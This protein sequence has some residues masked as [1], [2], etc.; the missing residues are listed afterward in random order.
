[1]T[2]YPAILDGEGGVWGIRMP[3][4]PGCHGGGTTPEAAFSDA[5]SA[6]REWAAHQLARGI[7]I[8]PASSIQKVLKEVDIKGGETIVMVPLLIDQGRPVRANVS[9]DAGL[10]EA[11]D[12]EAERRGLT[13]SGFL[14]S[15]AIEKIG[16]E[17]RGTMS[18]VFSEHPGNEGKYISPTSKVHRN[19]VRREMISGRFLGGGESTGKG[20]AA[21]GTSKTL[22]TKSSSKSVRGTKKGKLRT[23]HG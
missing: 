10:L 5:I 20:A 21:S 13:R 1:M 22:A 12:A 9:L 8:P 23:D 3:D 14:K 7:S 11:I 17:V 19:K 16:A 4:L 2:L 6:A 15:A 18:G